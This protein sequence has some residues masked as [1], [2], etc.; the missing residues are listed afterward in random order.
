MKVKKRCGNCRYWAYQSY[1]SAYNE[2]C[3]ECQAPIPDWI[4]LDVRKSDSRWVMDYSSCCDAWKKIR[5]KA[6]GCQCGGK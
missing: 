2:S 4:P 3:G 6:H 5:K 1:D